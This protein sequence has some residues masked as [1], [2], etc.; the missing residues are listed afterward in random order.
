MAGHLNISV[1][2]GR[3][4]SNRYR[5][6]IHPVD[7]SRAWETIGAVEQLDDGRWRA[8]LDELIATFP[9]VTKADRSVALSAMLTTLDRH[10]MA[11]APLH[12]FTSP[13]ADTGKS[14]LVDIAATLATG[15]ENAYLGR[16]P[17]E[18]GHLCC[19][20]PTPPGGPP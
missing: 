17:H 5:P 12:A 7:G 2:R 19:A 14:L 1:N 16:P 13:A 4:R 18:I 10:A 15:S 3:G 11:T 20:R 8:A 6:I 9:F